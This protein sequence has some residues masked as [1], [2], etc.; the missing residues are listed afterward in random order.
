MGGTHLS[1]PPCRRIPASCQ[2]DPPTAHGS[3]ASMTTKKV[4]S[5]KW[6]KVRARGR[7][8]E[9]G[10]HPT[11]A[12]GGSGPGRAGLRSRGPGQAAPRTR[13][14]NGN[15]C[16][17]EQGATRAKRPQC[18]SPRAEGCTSQEGTPRKRARN[19][20]GAAAHRTRWGPEA[21]PQGRSPMRMGQRAASHRQKKACT[22]TEAAT[23]RTRWGPEA[24]PPGRSQAAKT[25]KQSDDGEQ[26][27]RQG[28]RTTTPKRQ[29]AN[30]RGARPGSN[31]QVPRSAEA[32]FSV[33]EPDQRPSSTV[34]LQRDRAGNNDYHHKQHRQLPGRAL[35]AY[36]SAPTRWGPEA[37]PPER[38]NSAKTTKSPTKARPRARPCTS[39]Q[40]ASTPAANELVKA[41]G[42]Q[43]RERAARGA[44]T[45]CTCTHTW[46]SRLS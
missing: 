35:E 6:R 33:A 11:P 24:A 46:A 38:S 26:Q 42:L 7:C 8:T 25:T 3:T 10:S 32:K 14:A 37:A 44:C 31:R 1:P 36:P 34:S 13:Q 40:A 21:A 45:P 18:Y 17:E 20:T 15:K 43:Q 30:R 4:G 16:G 9:K 2:E 27:H 41:H 12:T 19:G 28:G 23:H 22:G 5:S 39:G 29:K